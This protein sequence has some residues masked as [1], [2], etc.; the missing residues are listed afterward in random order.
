MLSSYL[1]D[2]VCL[3]GLREVRQKM[4]MDIWTKNGKMDIFKV[5]LNVVSWGLRI[6]NLNF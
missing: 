6:K 2:F 4:D 1:E 5:Q 3:C